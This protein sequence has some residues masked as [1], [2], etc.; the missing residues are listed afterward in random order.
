MQGWEPLQRFDHWSTLL[1][2]MPGL[3]ASSW[4]GRL[5]EFVMHTGPSNSEAS[6]AG[7]GA[8]LHLWRAALAEPDAA[9]S[10][11]QQQQEG[12]ITPGQQSEV[13]SAVDI[14]YFTA[15]G[16]SVTLKQRAA[17]GTDVSG[18]HA[19]RALSADGASV[20]WDQ[21]L[22]AAHPTCFVFSP[23]SPQLS[24]TLADWQSQAPALHRVLRLLPLSSSGVAIVNA[25][26]PGSWGPELAA[27]SPPGSYWFFE[28]LLTH[29]D[30]AGDWQAS[31]LGVAYDW[32][33]GKLSSHRYSSV[34]HH[35]DAAGEWQAST[36][37]VA[38]DWASGKLSSHRY[39]WQKA[40]APLE[41]PH[42]DLARVLL[43]A[44]TPPSRDSSAS[45][46]S[47]LSKLSQQPSLQH[48]STT[49]RYSADEQQQLQCRHQEQQDSDRTQLAGTL[50]AVTSSW[51]ASNNNSSSGSSRGSG[52]PADEAAAGEAGGAAEAANLAAVGDDGFVTLWFPQGGAYARLPVQLPVAA[53]SSEAVTFEVGALHEN[54]TGLSRCVLQYDASTGGERRL[55]QVT[56]DEWSSHKKG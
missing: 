14:R 26:L 2:T 55:Q 3:N 19:D 38:Y 31:T 35:P 42:E 33:S 7:R 28:V 44:V 53:G 25:A 17:S 50:H 11:Q 8:I 30:A 1:T 4:C 49:Y 45:L 47:L 54:G 40:A 48:S 16:A 27:A 13:P 52:T 20:V 29:P 37:G 10:A 23:E 39:S 36:L 18:S 15:S 22:L 51:N 12:G 6:V 56:N 5:G 32:A 21:G 34:L 9:G 24:L 46:S 41:A 43:P